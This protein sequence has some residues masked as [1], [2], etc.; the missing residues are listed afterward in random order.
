MSFNSKT[1]RDRAISGKIRTPRLSTTPIAPLK[2]FRLFRF[3]A[4]IL[5]YGRNEK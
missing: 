4:A 2:K 5:N 3:F 1:V